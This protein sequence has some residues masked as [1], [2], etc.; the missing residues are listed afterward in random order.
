[1]LTNLHFNGGVRYDQY[2][3]FDPAFNPRLALIYNPYEKATI[4]ALYGT[5]FR[6]PNFFELSDPRFQNLR[7]EEITS[8]ELVYEQEIGRHLRSS[9]SGFYNQMDD[10]IVFNSGS[11]TNF[12]AETKGLELALSGIWTNGLRGRISYSLQ[13]TRNHSVDWEMPD[14]PSHLV[15]LNL[16]VPL[17]RNKIFAGVNS[18]TRVTADPSTTPRTPPASH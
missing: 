9:L 1:M 11:F 18:S 13:E 10:L 17:Y 5:A 16:S 12:D 3:D 7:P 15:K 8:Y 2:G 14:S 4:K 6:A